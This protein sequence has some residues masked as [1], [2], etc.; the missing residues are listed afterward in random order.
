MPITTIVLNVADVD[1]SVAFYTGH[2]GAQVVGEPTAERAVLDVVTATIELV[3]VGGDAPA[4]TWVPDDLQ[5]GFRHVG[6]KVDAVDPY[7]ERLKAA[8]VPFQLEPIEAEG[9]V[10]IT[11]FRDPDGTLLELV[12]RDLQYTEVYDEELVAAERAL[13]VP[14]RPRFDHVAVTVEDLDETSARYA[15]LGFTNIGTIAQPHDERGFDIYYLKSGDTVLEVFTYGVPKTSRTP[16]LDAP[17][18]VAAV[19]AG[20]PAEG[21][22]FEEVG[23]WAGRTVVADKDGLTTVVGG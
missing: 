11:F 14:D 5:R 10:R 1:R 15:P 20:T 23:S 19:L 4:S 18:Y 9:G 22:G 12:Q 13:G 3:A 21:S 7:V 16:Q 17:G 2:L 6:F 8:D